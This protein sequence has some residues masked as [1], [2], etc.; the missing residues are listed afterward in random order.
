[1]A[2]NYDKA[3]NKALNKIITKPFGSWMANSKAGKFWD[4]HIGREGLVG[5]IGDFTG[6]WESGTTADKRRVAL[7]ANTDYIADLK[8][9]KENVM[10]DMM[11]NFNAQ[12][13]MSNIGGLFAGLEGMGN[14]ATDNSRG[15]TIQ[16]ATTKGIQNMNL[17]F[18]NETK[19]AQNVM[20]SYDDRIYGAEQ[21][22]RDL[23]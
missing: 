18:D 1:M 12:N 4:T 3:R 5:A 13:T 21:Q 19:K 17:K 15:I 7:D 20:D 9:K 23:T 2:K 11:T 10:P 22:R 16:N 6:L 8:K 14:L